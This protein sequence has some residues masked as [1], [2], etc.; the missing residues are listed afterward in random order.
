MATWRHGN[1]DFCHVSVKCQQCKHVSSRNPP[2]PYQQL[3]PTV[4]RPTDHQPQANQEATRW[5][6]LSRKAED[7]LSAKQDEALHYRTQFEAMRLQAGHH[8]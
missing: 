1:C 8:V 4:P 2:T 5:R 3:H 7:S 6:E